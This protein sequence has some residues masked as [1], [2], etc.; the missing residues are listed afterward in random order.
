[1]EFNFEKVWR[2]IT[3]IKISGVKTLSKTFI[4][5]RKDSGICYFIAEIDFITESNG[6]SN[7]VIEMPQIKDDFV[8]CENTIFATKT[9]AGD[10]ID[11]IVR[12][13]LLP[14]KLILTAY[15]FSPD[16]KYELN[17]QLF[18]CLTDEKFFMALDK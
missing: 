9:V 12:M 16:T 10:E 11:T 8:P 7:V 2:D 5:Y 15:P 4:R 14:G 18:M 6:G 17:I 13:K 3:D 1:M